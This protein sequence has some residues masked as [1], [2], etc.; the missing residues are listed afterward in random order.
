M[1]KREEN[2][3]LTRTGPGTPMGE[4]FRRF[5]L[6]AL[7][8]SELPTPDS[9]PIRFR[10]L[11]EDLIAFRDSRGRPGFIA[12]NCPHR[13]A[14]LFFARNEEAGIRCV[15]HGWKFDVDG[16]CVDMPNEPAESDFRSKVKAT[17]YPSAEWGG[18]VGIYRGP[19]DRQPP[20]P[21]YHWCTLPD[22]SQSQARKW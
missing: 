22:A 8:P 11:S 19:R 16:N 17:A 4:L 5:W 3:L 9:D 10:I 20:L 13:G 21:N 1:L 15:Y 12:N 2:E 7:L 14:S 18:L 6:P